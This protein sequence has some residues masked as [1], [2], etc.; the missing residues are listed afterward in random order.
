MDGQAALV[1][2]CANQKLVG[3]EEGSD[4]EENING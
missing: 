1:Q 3:C 2:F 4:P